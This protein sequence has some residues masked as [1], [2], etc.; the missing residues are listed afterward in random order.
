MGKCPIVYTF[1]CVP[2]D[3]PAAAFKVN[4]KFFRLSIKGTPLKN[5]EFVP[6]DISYQKKV[7]MPKIQHFWMEYNTYYTAH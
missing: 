7:V 4:A 3:G 2:F 6:R 5:F 1:G